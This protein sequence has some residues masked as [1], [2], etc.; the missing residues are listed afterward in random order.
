ME[1]SS[2]DQLRLN[3]LLANPIQA[4]RIDEQRMT[5]HALSDKGEVKV[6]L[7][8]SGRTDQYLKRVRELL[9]GQVLGSPGGYPVY[10]KRWT[11][12]G[13]ARDENLGELLK[14]GEPEAVVAV[15]GA[16]GLTDDLARRVWWASPTSDTARCMLEREAVVQGHMGK[17]LAEHLVEHLAFET[18]A[19]TMIDSIRLVLQPGL[20]SDDMRK[21]LWDMGRRKR[22]Y[23]VGF[24]QA[25][26]DELPEPEPARADLESHA[27]ALQALAANGNHY[28]AL[29]HKV[30][31]TPGQTFIKVAQA[32]LEKP[33]A[34]DDVV[35]AVNAIEDYFRF[36]E[37]LRQSEAERD[38]TLIIEQADACCRA[39]DEPGV[40]ELLQSVPALSEEVKALLVLARCGE[41]VVIPVFARSDAIGTVMRR[42]L[43]PVTRPMFEQFRVLRTGH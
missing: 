14:L 41:A 7:N 21:K 23:F 18:E 40:A 20:I 36:S 10:L 15:A 17:L 38:I 26:A 29:L 33:Y 35:A 43:E 16:P 25:M 13:Q 19:I 28:A 22:A 42:K 3:V 27:A 1:L 5:L 30:L 12:M 31:D 24:M 2:E 32:A 4:I 8:P 11:R 39:G 9:S 34:Q 6:K 37:R